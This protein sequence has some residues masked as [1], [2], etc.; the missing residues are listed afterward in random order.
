[1]NTLTLTLP[2]MYADH[3]VTRVRQTLMQLNGVENVI[4]SSAFKTVLV[5]FDGKVTQDAIINA[6]TNAGY[7]PGELEL[8]KR[9]PDHTSDPAWDVLAP[10]IVTTSKVDLQMSGEFRKY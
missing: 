2:T 1:M 3:H 7:A 10:R 8:I 4:A 5:S 9:T 6:L